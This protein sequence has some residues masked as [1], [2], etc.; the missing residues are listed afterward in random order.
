[1]SNDVVIRRAHAG[2][3]EAIVELQRQ[4]LGE[5]TLPRSAEA[6]RWKHLDNPFGASSVLVAEAEGQLVGLRAFMAWSF[7]DGARVVRAVRAVDTVTHPGWQGRGLFTRLTRALC[8][9]VAGAGAAV[10][11]FNTPNDKSRPGYLKMG[12]HDL[13]RLMVWGRPLRPHALRPERVAVSAADVLASV[14][15]RNDT[16]RGYHTPISPAFLLWRYGRVPGLD[17]RAVCEGD[18][19]AVGR[20]RRRGRFVEA[21]ITEIVVGDGMAGVVRAARAVRHLGQALDAAYAIAVAPIGS[22]R[23]RALALAGF[24]PVPRIGPHFTVRPLVASPDAERAV[25]LGGWSLGLG[26]V[27]LF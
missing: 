26:D 16:E 1:M 7:L 2:D 5:G 23:A 24:V 18:A 10:F 17:Y 27:E 21:M 8:D 14:V 3:V 4:G 22:R 11:V 25:D 19:V 20:R 6:W 13:G 12:W 9:E 15:S